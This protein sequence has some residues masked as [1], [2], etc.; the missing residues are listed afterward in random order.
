[1]IRD[2][3]T[4]W[5]DKTEDKKITGVLLWDFS[6]TLDTE[7]LCSKLKIYMVS[8][9]PQWDGSDHLFNQSI[10]HIDNTS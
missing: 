3:A 10:N 8:K 2:T 5:A 4:V 9:T 1:M 7:I 6:D